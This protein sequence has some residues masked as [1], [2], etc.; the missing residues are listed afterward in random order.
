[1]SQLYH[2]KVIEREVSDLL[3]EARRITILTGAGISAES[4]IPTFRDALTGFWAHYDPEDLATEHGFR[5]DPQ[6]VWDWYESRRVAIEKAVPNA[7]HYAIAKLEE[8][9]PCTTLITQNVDGLHA[10]AGSRQPIELHGN[11][12]RVKCLEGCT[13]DTW[14]AR[15]MDGTKCPRCG[16]WL[17]PDVVW[18]G[19]MLS[20]KA[21]ASAFAASENCDVFLCVGTSAL[22]HPAASLPFEAL[23]AGVKVIE[24]NPNPTP[25]SCEATFVLSGKAAEILPDLLSGA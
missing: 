23:E 18:F 5:R 25:L 6:L 21:T 22:V 13:K 15:E 3:R 7:G 14:A 24:V 10:R 11:L 1:V 12:H 9:K 16:A 17:R 20:E 19:E 4:G 8:R 2:L